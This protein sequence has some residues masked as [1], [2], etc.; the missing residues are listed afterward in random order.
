MAAQTYRTLSVG[1]ILVSL[2]LAGSAQATV[3][4]QHTG[5]TNPISQGWSASGLIIGVSV[6]AVL[7]D[8][9]SGTDAWKVD[10]NSTLLGSTLM[11]DQTP[12][13]GSPEAA[14]IANASTTGWRLSTLLRIPDI[15]D[16]PDASVFMIYYDGAKR[17]WV[18]FGTD[19][20]GDPI[21]D[22]MGGGSFTLEG[23]GSSAYHRY[24]LISNPNSG[25]ADLFIDGIERLT[26]YTGD[27]S[28]N[29][30]QIAFGS[31]QSHSTGQGNYAEV[32][33]ETLPEPTALL[34]AT[35][36][37]GLLA[38]MIRPGLS[39]RGRARM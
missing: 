10:D 7:N 17:Y 22:L 18:N 24:D 12:S 32:L 33:F 31:A 13:A 15:S 20:D 5:G 29:T 11:Y 36:G 23:V 38:L 3:I 16:T 27:N 34:L 26:G 37:V 1:A 6:G 8:L 2:G 4:Y 14:A 25:S 39:R 19:A 28:V 21:V 9:G 30:P 35:L